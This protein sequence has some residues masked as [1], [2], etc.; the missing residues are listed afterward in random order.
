MCAPS[1]RA[2]S[3]LHDV[4]SFGPR[5]QQPEI[6]VPFA[7]S[8]LPSVT[9]GVRTAEDPAAM[10]RTVSAAVHSVDSDVALAYLRPMIM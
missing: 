2:I 10:S 3:N 9:I 6:D 8:L 7:Q 5:N 4:R 1:A